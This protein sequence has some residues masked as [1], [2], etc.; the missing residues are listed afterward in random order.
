MSSSQTILITGGN[1]GLGLEIVRAHYGSSNAYTVIIGSRSLQKAEDAIAGLKKEI[2]SS[3]S[4]LSAVQIDVESDDSVNQ[5]FKTVSSRHGHIDTLINNAGA[6]LGKAT[7]D[8][9]YSLREGWNKSWDVVSP[10]PIPNPNQM[11]QW[12]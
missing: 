3:K 10:A 4:A 2:P 1:A 8:G 11:H 5:A 6:G 7:Q 12:H 9:E